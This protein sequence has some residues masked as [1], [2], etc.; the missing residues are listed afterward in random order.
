MWLTAAEWMVVGNDLLAA[1]PIREVTLTTGLDW[2]SPSMSGKLRLT[3][4]DVFYDC[5]WAFSWTETNP[6]HSR[7]VDYIFATEWPNITF[8]LP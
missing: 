1:N 2:H 3:A 6:S 8:H 5:E 4:A 7:V